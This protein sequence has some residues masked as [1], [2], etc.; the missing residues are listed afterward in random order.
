MLGRQVSTPRRQD[1]LLD[2][3]YGH[4]RPLAKWG[5]QLRKS[6]VRFT[7][8]IEESKVP[9]L[10]GPQLPPLCQQAQGGSLTHDSA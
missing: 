9:T 3:P 8:D 6:L 4:S 7:N 5:H 2:G 10:L 1:L